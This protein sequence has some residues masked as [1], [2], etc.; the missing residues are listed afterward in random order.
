MIGAGGHARACIDVVE[1]QDSFQIAGLIGLPSEVGDA[2]MGYPVVA[3]DDE[4]MELAD[5]YYHALVTVGQIK[6][7]ATRI[8]LYQKAVNAG[9]DMPTITSPNAY[10]SHNATIGIG[11]I[12]M[13]GATINAGAVVGKNCIIN[14]HALIEHDAKVEDHCHIATG[15][16]VNGGVRVGEGSFVGSGAAIKQGVVIGRNCIIGM[17]E[18]VKENQADNVLIPEVK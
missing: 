9:F 10:V 15:A 5:K 7:A 3:T 18:T 14:S 11:T 17:G 2:Y 1:R 13:H 12:V 4:L 16:L 8:G 6:S